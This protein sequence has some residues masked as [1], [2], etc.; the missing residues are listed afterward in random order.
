MGLSRMEG[1]WERSGNGIGTG[2]EWGRAHPFEISP[3]PP[4]RLSRKGVPVPTPTPF[5][6]RS[7]NP[8]IRD[9]PFKCDYLEISFSY[10]DRGF[11]GSFSGRRVVQNTP[12]PK[13]GGYAYP[14]PPGIYASDFHE[15]NLRLAGRPGHA[16]CRGTGTMYVLGVKK[17]IVNNFLL[18]LRMT[19]KLW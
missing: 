18:P 6:L 17:K 7:H 11:D 19:V 10:I 13:N 14:H 3:P 1:L 8:S 12:P 15:D 4:P 9:K 5:P 2:W 16:A